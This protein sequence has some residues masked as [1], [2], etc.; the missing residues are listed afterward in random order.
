LSRATFYTI[1]PDEPLLGEAYADQGTAE[2]E[3]LA[4]LERYR[5]ATEAHEVTALAELY[6][7]FL[8]AQRAAQQRY[9]DNVRDLRVTIDNVDVAVAGD[10]AVASYSRTDD[11]TD[12]RTGRP[13]HLVVRLTKVLRR[14]DGVWKL[15]GGGEARDCSRHAT[16]RPVKRGLTS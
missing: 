10:E 12:A 3:I 16:L 6:V 9:F 11:F 5:R 7:E 14:H 13:M 15:A 4:V 8:P 1:A 2:A